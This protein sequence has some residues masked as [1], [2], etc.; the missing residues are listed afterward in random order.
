M[1]FKSGLTLVDAV[2]GYSYALGEFL[3]EGG[4]GTAFRARRFWTNDPDL[5]VDD[6]QVCLKVTDDRESW[7]FESY[8]GLLVRGEKRAVQQIDTFAF[9]AG[10]GQSRTVRH[11]IV[12]EVMEEGTLEESLGQGL[13]RDD[14]WLR[15]EL[16]AM[17]GLL[18]KLHASNATHG[19]IHSGNV[20]VRRRRLVL[21]DFGLSGHVLPG[22]R[23]WPR[24]QFRPA[25]PDSLYD[26]R[27]A[28]WRPSD[29]LYELGLMFAE[30]LD[31]LP[32]VRYGL[33]TPN[34]M[35][36]V[37]RQAQIP[38]DLKDFL[39]RL[40]APR[41]TQRFTDAGQALEAFDPEPSVWA[42]TPRSLRGL[43]VVFTGRLGD[44]DRADARLWV[45]QAGGSVQ[46]KVNG[47]TKV[48]VVGDPSRYYRVSARRGTKLA[49]AYRA[50]ER[51]QP[52]ALI[53]L[54]DLKRLT[55]A[56]RRPRVQ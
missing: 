12:T 30:I 33:A 48:V 2:G 53:G 14:A 25:I 27:R 24:G 55:R 28:H 20:F 21:G 18:A 34:E 31:D 47:Q 52:I 15:R 38:T 42:P 4:F 8:M 29:D 16:K 9:S 56:R 49:E 6:P 3:G 54:E 22:Q 5:A 43:P 41:S 7:L 36:T 40:T 23:A 13:S 26:G 35:R 44:V 39:L 11:A 10:R 32:V 19:D 17:L 45:L 51:G 1:K 46:G 50:A 37:I